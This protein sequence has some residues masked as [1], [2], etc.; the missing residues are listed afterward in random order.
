MVHASIAITEFVCVTSCRCT[1]FNGI[2]YCTVLY[3]TFHTELDM[4]LQKNET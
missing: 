3:F 4:T 1:L 2:I